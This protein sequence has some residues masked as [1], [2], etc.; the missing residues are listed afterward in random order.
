V[1]CADTVSNPEKVAQHLTI[2]FS[3]ERMRIQ[4]HT[5]ALS[6]TLLLA[7]SS[8]TPFSMAQEFV[9]AANQTFYLDLDTQEGAYSQW[10]QDDTASLTSLRAKVRILRVGKD[11]RYAPAFTIAVQNRTTKYSAGVQLYSPDRKPLLVFRDI[12]Q[13][14]YSYVGFDRR[15]KLDEPIDIE[16]NWATPKVLIVKVG[17]ETK[18]LELASPIDSIAISASTGELKVEP[19]ELGH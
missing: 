15:L 12:R 14:K 16:M 4:L 6:L 19:L 13:D 8:V 2:V 10:R 9:G 5:L 3:E 1:I 17:G 7:M 18:K 11:K